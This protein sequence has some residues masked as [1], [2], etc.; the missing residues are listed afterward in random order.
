MDGM[1]RYASPAR[2]TQE[3]D[4]FNTPAQNLQ[5]SPIT[6][7]PQTTILPPHPPS[8]PSTPLRAI[9]TVNFEQEGHTPKRSLPL[10]EN[11]SPDR[12]T[13]LAK[14]DP[15][16]GVSAS[17]HNPNPQSTGIPLDQPDI[18]MG[19]A[20]QTD[21]A[22]GRKIV[23]N[24]ITTSKGL[25]YTAPPPGGFPTP[26][27]TRPYAKN[28]S[29]LLAGQVEALGPHTIWVRPWKMKFI[30]KDDAQE[31]RDAISQVLTD[32]FERDDPI[33]LLATNPAPNAIRVYD[34]TPW[35]FIVPKLSE[36]EYRMAVKTKVIASNTATLFILPATQ[37]IPSFVMLIKGIDQPTGKA[38]EGALIVKETVQRVMRDRV[39]TLK[40]TLENLSEIIKNPGIAISFFIDSIEANAVRV[41]KSKTNSHQNVTHWSITAK[42]MPPFTLFDSYIKF[43]E[44][45]DGAEFQTLGYGIGKVA[46]G[47]ETVTCYNCKSSDHPDARCPFPA[48][49]GW[50][51]PTD[52][53]FPW[54]KAEPER[55]NDSG[56][57]RKPKRGGYRGS[58]NKT[59]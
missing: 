14:L 13:K 8:M 35:Y 44:I 30:K 17:I 21:E 41:P 39:P 45:Y 48:I 20:E 2:Q 3:K 11:G 7:P 24:H 46:K 37:Q 34:N 56:R 15:P 6:S 33:E 25:T 26:Q 57:G 32:F 18:P 1:S 31:E 22:S 12:S 19:D 5:M 47:S 4:I 10:E 9:N 29:P 51:A 55:Q 36:N 42:S 27:L 43:I 54:S 49:P 50:L 52:D 16:A 58:Y 23:G 40:S 59:N 28:V 38:D 53:K